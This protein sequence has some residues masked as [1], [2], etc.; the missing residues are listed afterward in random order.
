T[1]NPANLQP[2]EEVPVTTQDDLNSAVDV[3]RKAF[4][5]WLKVLYE[6]RRSAV[7]AFADAVEQVKTDFRDLLVSEQRKPAAD[8]ETDVA[9]AWIRGLAHIELPEDVIEDDDKRTVITRYV[10]IGVVGAIIPWNFPFHLA[11]SKITPALLTGN[12]VIIKPSPVSPKPP[13][14]ERCAWC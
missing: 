4:R 11:A 14:G 13:Q 8:V 1:V 9:I 5:T 2:K 3:A 10:P 6:D 7:L 12:V